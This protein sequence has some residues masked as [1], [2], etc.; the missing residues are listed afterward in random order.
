M[1]KFITVSISAVITLIALFTVYSIS[2]DYIYNGYNRRIYINRDTDESS[3][4][5]KD[6]TE[7]TI[8]TREMDE[9]TLEENMAIDFF[10]IKAVNDDI[11]GWINI[12]NVGYY[13]VMQTSN[14]SYYLSHNEYKEYEKQGV[15]FLDYRCNGF[16]NTALIYGHHYTSGKMFGSLQKYKE[17]D[18]FYNNEYVTVFDGEKFYYYKP[19]TIYL[20]KTRTYAV[21]LNYDS[22]TE[23]S[24]FLKGAAE[25][26]MYETNFTGYNFQALFLQTCDYS[27]YNARLV[28]GF[29]LIGEKIYE[30]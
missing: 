11:I 28:L 9:L 7:E 19:F 30:N 26:S 6:Y 24:D 15:P 12:P 4:S 22:L 3:D 23:R 29:R 21:K 10:N 14:N 13:P 1:H 25:A 27:F 20:F 8:D 18:F 5:H 17:K 2:Q 16:R